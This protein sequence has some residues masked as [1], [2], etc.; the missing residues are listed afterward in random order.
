VLDADHQA[1][2]ARVREMEAAL[3][4]APS[5]G[6][7]YRAF[8]EMISVL[9][10]HIGREEAYLDKLTSN[11][12]IAHRRQH[13]QLHNFMVGTLRHAY[14]ELAKNLKAE[15]TR[16]MFR[17]VLERIIEELFTSDEEMIDLFH[18]EGITDKG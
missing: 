2:I 10:D 17:A 18:K 4:S 9:E 15:R 8:T 1:I 5:S 7:V 6:S 16:T 13:C 12:G 14:T 11:D 3:D